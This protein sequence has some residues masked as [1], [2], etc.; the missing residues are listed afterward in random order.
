MKA[1]T[2]NASYKGFVEFCN[3]QTGDRTI[4][5][6]SW[7]SCSVGDYLA[8][9]E[10]YSTDVGHIGVDLQ[11]STHYQREG[12]CTDVFMADVLSSQQGHHFVHLLLPD[13]VMRELSSV[14]DNF[15]TYGELC[16][17]LGYVVK[18]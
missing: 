12:F 6:S 7:A 8:T 10:G 17:F 9:V 18:D 13:S 15:D 16:E 2:G 14:C 11:A 5:H 3:A 4:D 1:N